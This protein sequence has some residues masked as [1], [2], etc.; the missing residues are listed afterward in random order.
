VDNAGLPDEALDEVDIPFK[1]QKIM[2]D[3]NDQDTALTRNTMTEL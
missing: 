1:M 2:Q 3:I